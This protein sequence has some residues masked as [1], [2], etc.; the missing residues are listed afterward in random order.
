MASRNFWWWTKRSVI[1]VIG[2][3][4]FQAGA[5][6]PQRNLLV[7]VRLAAKTDDEK[8]KSSAAVTGFTVSSRSAQ[9][10]ESQVQSVRILNGKQG[11][12]RF[13][14][15]LPFQWIS[16][17]EVLSPSPGASAGS[18]PRRA[19]LTNSVTWL[20]AGHVLSIRP[21]WQGGRVANVAI[22]LDATGVDA[23][24]AA[25]IPAQSRVHIV[26]T[27]L[28]PIGQWTTFAETGPSP[29]PNDRYAWKSAAQSSRQRFQIKV[30][31]L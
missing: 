27:V 26:T 8:A 10:D 2:A 20:Q 5:Q 29:E 16:S 12:I 7:E 19:A 11:S 18:L 23:G 31:P 22:E 15:D 21:L 13:S 24:A 28:A 4:A 14:R 3:I 30:S 17:A 9:E 1:A 25:E 6:P